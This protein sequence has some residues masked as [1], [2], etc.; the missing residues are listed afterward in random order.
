ML[1][2]VCVALV[3]MGTLLTG[4]VLL[5]GDGGGQAVSEPAVPGTDIG[6]G[7]RPNLI[8]PTDVAPSVSQDASKSSRPT[9]D[10]SPLA[11]RSATSASASPTPSTL[12]SASPSASPPSGEP[13]PSGTPGSGPSPGP[14]PSGDWRDNDNCD[15]WGDGD[16][17]GNGNGRHGRDDC[18]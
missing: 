16:R 3:A 2:G 10:S 6:V 7:G 15:E 11:T 1:L 14:T 12:R 13:T 17:N 8:S 4:A 18:W 9:A 5:I